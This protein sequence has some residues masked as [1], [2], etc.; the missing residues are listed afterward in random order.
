MATMSERIKNSRKRK[1]MTQIELGQRMSLSQQVITNYERGIRDPVSKRCSR[2]RGH[3]ESVWRP[4][5]PM[6]PSSPRRRQ[7]GHCRGASSRCGSAW[8]PRRADRR[9]TSPANSMA[10]SGRGVQIEVSECLAMMWVAEPG[11][12]SR[13]FCGTG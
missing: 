12:S 7:A 8:Q 2:L 11:R 13:N 5:S 6:N 1:G 9:P 3:W 4:L 10:P